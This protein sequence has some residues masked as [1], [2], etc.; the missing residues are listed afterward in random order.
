MFG[1]ERWL[2]VLSAA[3]ALVA[4][5]ACAGGAKLS[6]TPLHESAAPDFALHTP[7]GR[8]FH[9]SDLR[10]KTVVLTF[11]YTH[12]PDVCPAIA[13]R[14]ALANQQLG[15][16]AAKVA[17]VSVSVDPEGDTPAS[18]DAFTQEHGLA[19]LG[20]RWRYAIG[21]RLDLA[22]VWQAYGIGASPQPAAL[23]TLRPDPNGPPI[24]DHNAVLYLID[25]QGRERTVLDQDVTVAT[26]VG[27]LRQL[28]E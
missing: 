26:L 4:S 10:G 19:A 7:D 13:G 9:L 25:A 11:L 21:S 24:I 6:G 15:K 14:L 2:F 22:P 12:C 16:R 1:G 20:D 27:D 17:F 5:A 3:L 18:V 23:A 28:T 8:S